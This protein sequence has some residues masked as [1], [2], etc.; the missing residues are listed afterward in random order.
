M[1][2][3]NLAQNRD[4]ADV[5]QDYVA[6]VCAMAGLVDYL[7]INISSPNTRGLRAMQ[8]RDA[9]AA[10]LA[11][12]REARHG[13]ARTGPEGHAPAKLVV[14][15]APDLEMDEREG[16]A[17][18]VLAGGVDGLIIGNSTTTRPEA[19]RSPHRDEVGGLTGRPLFALSTEVLGTMYRLTG[20]RI[21]LV[22]C[23][24]VED[25]ATAYA[26]IRAGASLIQLYTALVY[27]GPGVVARIKAELAARL[28]ADAF[29]NLT[30]AV[31]A[32][33][34]AG[35]VSEGNR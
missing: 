1:V 32:D 2:G 29:D 25:G 4:S 27:E 11:R 12:V 14:K 9:L 19:L 16:I 33:H 34:R 10:L 24:G 22:G 15:I 8:A 30:D 5:A 28:R 18:T 23:G 13:A 35:T 31:G 21:P 20:G 7:V 26:K 6:G 17:E 3:G